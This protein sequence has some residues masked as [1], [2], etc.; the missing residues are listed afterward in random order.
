MKKLCIALL[1]TALIAIPAF[2]Y[3]V[4]P[5]TAQVSYAQSAQAAVRDTQTTHGD[6]TWTW[7]ICG[8]DKVV[9]ESISYDVQYFNPGW[10]SISIIS[11]PEHPGKY[12]LQIRGSSGWW[13]QGPSGGWT[14]SERVRRWIDGLK[15][16]NGLIIFE[17]RLGYDS[18]F[19]VRTLHM[20]AGG[21]V[22]NRNDYDTFIYSGAVQF[23]TLIGTPH[24]SFCVS[25]YWTKGEIW[26]PSGYSGM[27]AGAVGC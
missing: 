17:N 16:V 1:L 15:S 3:H 8:L 7:R 5:G 12:C 13:G 4:S 19:H 24:P 11:D 23:S 18:V 26:P 10:T 6:G 27:D 21:Q 25:H 14:A 22:H 2:A 9:A 20:D